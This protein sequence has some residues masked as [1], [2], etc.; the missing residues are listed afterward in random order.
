MAKRKNRSEKETVVN[1]DSVS[2]N[3]FQAYESSDDDETKIV[4]GEPV[5]ADFHMYDTK[6]KKRRK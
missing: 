1:E 6:N 2:L 3:S 5:V 4:D